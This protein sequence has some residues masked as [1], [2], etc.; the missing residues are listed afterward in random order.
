MCTCYY[1]TPVT[2][3]VKGI[4]ITHNSRCLFVRHGDHQETITDLED[5]WIRNILNKIET[6]YKNSRSLIRI[7]IALQCLN[8]TVM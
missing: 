1:C 4:V 6:K 2:G 8:F 3:T 5:Q 7:R